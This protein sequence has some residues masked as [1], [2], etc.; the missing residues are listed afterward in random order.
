MPTPVQSPVTPS[1]RNV[2]RF[3]VHEKIDLCRGIFAFLVVSAHALE[4]AWVLNPNE[5]KTL[6]P[7]AHD[8]L[9]YVL[10][11]GLYYVM[12]FFVLSGYCIQL[13]VQRLM[14]TGTFPLKTYMI[15]RLTRILPLYYL[16][17]LFTVVLELIIAG[18]RAPI[19]GNGLRSPVL[20][21]QILVIQNFTQTYGSFAQ[22]WSITNEAF[23]YILF[24]LLAAVLAR[25]SLRPAI[26]GMV[27]CLGF[28]IT[29]QVAYRSGFRSPVIRST[30]LLFGLGANWFLG[31]LVAQY[32]NSLVRVPAVR[33]AARFWT[34]ILALTMGLW[35]SQLISLEVAYL[36]SGVAFT[37]MLVRFLAQDADRGPA[38][39]SRPAQFTTLI[40]LA[41]YPTYL[42]H[43]QIL[44]IMGSAILRWN[45][46]VPWWLVWLGTTAITITL[47]MAL[48]HLVE[49]P[50]MA[51]R[52][53]LL[54]RLEAAAQPSQVRTGVTSP[55]WGVQQ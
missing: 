13:S 8:F 36:S 46:S 12:G 34:L 19:W 17:L 7:L 6:G 44:L 20:F 41:S 39:R 45:P 43:A 23:Y 55:S 2:E 32:R 18:N 40:G 50:I 28:G 48:G 49:Q 54:K 27:L 16:A 24:G 47:G 4:M 31:A 21:S 33:L 5:S 53:G 52:A 22:S 38:Q 14:D 26:L 9:N 1:A 35:F 37:L 42:F 51:W 3:S 11:T 25:S 29:M 15:A 30:G 10:G